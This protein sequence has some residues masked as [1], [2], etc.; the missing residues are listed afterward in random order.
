MAEVQ[1]SFGR[2]IDGYLSLGGM[3]ASS[4][5]DERVTPDRGLEVLKH[6]RGRASCS[7]CGAAC[8]E[9]QVGAASSLRAVG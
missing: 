9:G 6:R 8:R 5:L 1:P 7:L 3:L 4:R 2:R